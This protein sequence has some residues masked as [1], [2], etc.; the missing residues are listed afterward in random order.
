M[1]PGRAHRARRLVLRKAHALKKPRQDR[2]KRLRIDLTSTQKIDGRQR[3]AS[4]FGDGEHFVRSPAGVD[5]L[6]T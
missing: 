2:K 4:D 6:R 5:V 3:I 1:R